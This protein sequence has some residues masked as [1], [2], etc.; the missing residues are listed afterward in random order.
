M[1]YGLSRRRWLMGAGL[2]ALGAAGCSVPQAPL[3][4]GTIVFPGYE[5]LFLAEQL[6]LLND[7]SVRLVEMHSNTDNLRALAM[8][9]LEAATLTLD[10]AL[11]G[12]SNGIPLRVVMVMDVSAGADVVMARAPISTPGDLRGRRV[13]VEDSAVGALMLAAVLQAGGLAVGD[14]TR[15]PVVLP[16]TGEV[17]RSGEVDAVVTAEPWASQLQA[18]KAVRLFDSKAIPGRIVDVLAVREDAFATHAA[19]LERL[20]RSHFQALAYFR[21][22]A[23]DAALRMAPRLQVAPEAVPGTFLGLDLPDLQA[24]IRLLTGSGGLA[25]SLPEMVELLHAQG[26]LQRRVAADQLLDP[27]WLEAL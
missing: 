2:L 10:E 8:G 18:D 22:S 13:G 26:L 16:R 20:M 17:F 27:R 1:L 6:G 15:V 11:T 21:Q 19:P 5:F 9:R 12:L 24:N 25:S 14:V 3:R 7:A 23:A 4:V